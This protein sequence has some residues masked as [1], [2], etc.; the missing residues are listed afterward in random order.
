MSN[1]TTQFPSAVRVD[2]DS[3]NHCDVFYRLLASTP[4]FHR[5]DTDLHGRCRCHNNHVHRN[6][7]HNNGHNND[8]DDHDIN[9]HHNHHV[10]A[11]NR[12]HY[13]VHCTSHHHDH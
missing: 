12:S 11:D 2:R 13:G 7:D 1:E 10:A 9:N 3:G 6:R 8:N 4:R 5:T